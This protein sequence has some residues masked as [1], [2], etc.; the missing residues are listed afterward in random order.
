MDGEEAHLTRD[1]SYVSH[2]HKHASYMARGEYAQQLERWL[3]VFPREQI[4]VVR[5]EDLYERSAEVFAR[6]AD[7]LAIDPD[8]TIPFAVHNQTA[9]PALEPAI[10]RRL[11]EHFAPLNARLAD[12]LG[13]DPGWS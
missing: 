7:F 13:W 6:V 11:S 1:P 2:P 5:S 8:V 4:L 9:G 12:L 3:G 10:R